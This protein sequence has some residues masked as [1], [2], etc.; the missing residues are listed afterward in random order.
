RASNPEKEI[1]YAETRWNKGFRFGCVGASDD[2][3]QGYFWLITGPGMPTTS[4]LASSYNERAV[5]DAL[6]AGHTS[7]SLAGTVVTL[8]T[9]LRGMGYVDIG[10]D[11]VFV[12]AGTTGHLRISVQRAAGFD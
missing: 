2:H 8:A 5:L 11:E 3:F 10:G 9:D 12:P 7:V 6:R 1:D 4:V